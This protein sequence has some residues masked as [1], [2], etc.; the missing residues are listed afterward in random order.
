LGWNMISAKRVEEVSSRAAPAVRILVADDH[1][2]VRRGVR[3]LL[4][5]KPGWA[6]CGEAVSGA[7]AILKAKRLKPDVVV[8]DIT[9]PEI[10][11]LEATRQIRREVPKTGVIILSMHETY[12]TVREVVDA[13][14]QGYVLKSDLDLGLITAIENLLRGGT[15]F[16]PKVTELVMDGYLKGGAADPAPEAR[17]STPGRRI[18]PRQTEVV[19]LLAEGKTNKEVALALG[20]SVKTAETHRTQ[21]MHKLGL[22]SFS[23]LVKYAVREKLVKA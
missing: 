7:D 18:T 2:I 9:M 16:S 23:D 10:N 14:A 12:Q 3:S 5:T 1:S 6:V 13:G 21:I 8:M 17:A 4:E 22:K 15:F 11:G 20:I 19:R